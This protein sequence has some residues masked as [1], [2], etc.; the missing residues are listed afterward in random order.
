MWV[1]SSCSPS[2]SCDSFHK[3]AL[4][5]KLYNVLVVGVPLLYTHNYAMHLL[6]VAAYN[7]V[8]VGV[9]NTNYCDQYQAN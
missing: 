5:N 9:V 3:T 7:K 8:V 4:E 1:A 6:H 2:L